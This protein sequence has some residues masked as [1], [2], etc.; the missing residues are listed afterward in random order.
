M[1]K[2]R[3]VNRNCS[4][5]ALL[6]ALLVH[7]PAAAVAQGAARDSMPGGAEPPGAFTRVEAVRFAGVAALGGLAYLA[8][9]QVRDAL[10]NRSAGETGVLP[11]MNSFAYY[12]GEPGV[13][14]L[15]IA[16]WSTGLV[17]KRPTLAVTG[18]RAMESVAVSGLVTSVVKELTG[19]AR[20]DVPP[21]AKDDW[22]LSRTLWRTGNDYK[23]MP[24]GHAT[25]AFAFAT[26][27]T[28]AVADLAPQHTRTVAITTF[29]LATMTSWQ[30]IY[31]DRHRLSD[32]TVGAGVGV[33]TALAIR[34]WHATR[35]DDPIDRFF[36]RPVIAPA[37]GGGMLVG[38]SILP[39]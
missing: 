14:V 1:A 21:H 32:V 8:D 38:M 37:T 10:R 6:A 31:D 17:T 5:L 20:P 23:A 24:S 35:P 33:V 18:F 39:R 34:R 26:A 13:A 2:L 15:G 25:V 3:C 7:L 28:G 22:Q 11:A 12:Y 27:V 29:G 30:R 9:G 16:M 4:F 19:R 36:L